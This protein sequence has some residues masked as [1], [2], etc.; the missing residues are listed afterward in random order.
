MSLARYF[1]HRVLY[2]YTLIPL[3]SKKL[4]PILETAAP[5]VSGKMAIGKIDCTEE[6]KLC[7][8]HKI[9]GYPTLKFSMDGDLFDYTLGRTEEDIVSFAERLSRPTL[10]HVES[11]EHAMKFATEETFGHGVA[12]VCHDPNAPEGGLDYMTKSSPLLQVCSQAARKERAHAHFLALQRDAD[13]SSLT[14]EPHVSKSADEG[15]EETKKPKH[16]FVCRLEK[17]VAPRCLLE[18]NEIIDTDAVLDFVKVNN[19]ETVTKLGAQNFHRIGRL[20]R[21]L[22]IG[23]VDG[24][25]DEQVKKLT[26]ELTKF[27]IKGPEKLTE[28]Y[29]LGWMDGVKWAK[30]LEQFSIKKE[31]LPLVFALDVPKRK[32]WLSLDYKEKSIKEFL[33]AIEE[34]DIEAKESDGVRGAGFI[35]NI[36]N[37]FFN[38]MPWSLFLIL[39]AAAV[40]AVVPDAKELR[41]PHKDKK[42]ASSGASQQP[43]VDSLLG[44]KNS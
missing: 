2:P 10:S 41:P 11:V 19:V 6:K 1:T 26:S 15:E 37:G 43:A 20:G 4:G 5:Q 9:R 39:A 38:W 13:V 22:V 29:Y 25:E 31:D 17:G 36:A 44:K 18:K 32:Y 35:K 23:V 12:F 16:G 8:K 14:G 24:N 30:F 21:P 3:H 40:V 28:K 27:G 34:G 42:A 7:D 33:T